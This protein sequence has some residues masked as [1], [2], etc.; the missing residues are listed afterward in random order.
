MPT[1]DLHS[2]TDRQF[3]FLVA[4][5]LRAIGLSEVQVQ[6]PTT[7][8]FDIIAAE[9]FTSL[10]APRLPSKWGIQCKLQKSSVGPGIFDN[11]PDEARNRDVRRILLAT[12]GDFTPRAI[13][14]GEMLEKT[15]SAIDTV[16]FW[17]ERQLKQQLIRY[18]AILRHYFGIDFSKVL[19]RNRKLIPKDVEN[20]IEFLSHLG[21]VPV[22]GLLD[23]LIA[24]D[25]TRL[26]STRPSA[27]VGGELPSVDDLIQKYDRP[28]LPQLLHSAYDNS[29]PGPY[30]HYEWIEHVTV[31]KTKLANRPELLRFVDAVRYK[32]TWKSPAPLLFEFT[33]DRRDW[34]RSH[35]VSRNEYSW[36]MG[37]TVE[38]MH[39][40]QPYISVKDAFVGGIRLGISKHQV[41][42]RAITISMDSPLMT[43]LQGQAVEVSYV[44]K[45]VRPSDARSIVSSIHAPTEAYSFTLAVERGFPAEPRISQL[46]RG[47]GNKVE[48]LYNGDSTPPNIQVKATGRIAPSSGLAIHW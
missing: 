4:D 37:R 22:Q 29:W 8:T 31:L 7:P 2:L 15:N 14:R 48:V 3:E 40:V 23:A 18:P 47:L 13:T 41:S 43:M 19:P 1:L 39:S 27:Q 25:V 21:G 26:L 5:L 30:D 11:V 9:S 33:R 45:N 35:Y 17:N 34:E 46:F 16:V 12:A 32:T 10:L 42:T 36:H 6:P 38:D 20:L 28:E 24:R 44:V